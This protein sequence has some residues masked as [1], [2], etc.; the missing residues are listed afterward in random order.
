MDKKYLKL[1][2]VT[3][4]HFSWMKTTKQHKYQTILHHYYD[5]GEDEKRGYFWDLKLFLE[6]LL[7]TNFGN[8]DFHYEITPHSLL[9]YIFEIFH[10][11]FWQLWNLCVLLKSKSNSVLARNQRSIRLPLNSPLWRSKSHQM[12]RNLYF[13]RPL[14]NISHD[15]SR[16][17]ALYF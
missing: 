5:F 10:Y 11:I 1:I 16:S 14:Y 13:T 3:Y 7:R 9:N 6:L 4:S 8:F 15:H 17:I 12:K 2:S